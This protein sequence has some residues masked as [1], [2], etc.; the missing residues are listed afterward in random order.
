VRF[1][2]INGFYVGNWLFQES[3]SMTLDERNDEVNKALE[4]R[5]SQLNAALEAHE[6]KL[7]A[8]MVPKNAQSMYCSEDNE[9]LRSGQTCGQYQSYIGMIKLRGAWR[10][11]H[12]KHYEDY[13]G[14]SEDIDWKPLVEASIEDRI[15]AAEHVD[16][17]RDAIVQEKE[18]LVPDVEKA[19]ATLAKSLERYGEGRE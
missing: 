4:A 16:E 18:K 5:F 17:L 7:K 3:R 13:C 9:D 19:I 15:K 8:M 12:A 10:L 1:N 11:C 2:P 14:L 6:A